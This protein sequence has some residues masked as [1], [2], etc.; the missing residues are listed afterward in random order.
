MRFHPILIGLLGLL[1]SAGLAKD[2]IEPSTGT[3]FPGTRTFLDQGR[4]NLTAVATAVRNREGYRFYTLCLYVNLIELKAKTKGIPKNQDDLARLLLNGGI[5]HAF[6]TR[7]YAGVAGIRRLDF[8]KENVLKTWPA[9]NPEAPEV[10][11]FLRFI[12][13]DLQRGET[14]EIWIDGKGF[15]FGRRGSRPHAQARVPELGKAFS[16]T[17]FGDQAMDAQ[18]R[19]QLLEGFALAL[20]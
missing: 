12:R 9:F 6:V 10:Q 13:E 7:F 17:Y 5:S 8:L 18:L 14:T 3:R 1:S 20:P 11:D 16:A 15:I 2:L 19:R 4:G